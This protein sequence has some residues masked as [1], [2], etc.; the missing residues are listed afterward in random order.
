M[1]QRGAPLPVEVQP[2]RQC[3]QLVEQRGKLRGCEPGLLHGLARG[4]R[5]E[6]RVDVEVDDGVLAERE[7]SQLTFVIGGLC[8]AIFLLSN[9]WATPDAPTQPP[10]S[11]DTPT[12]SA[13][14]RIPAM[15]NHR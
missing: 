1:L 15:A 12:P 14:R 3:A 10:A 2:D 4:R 13:T 7:R 11:T 8:A 9:L 5:V 6:C